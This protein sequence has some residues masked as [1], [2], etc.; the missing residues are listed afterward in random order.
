MQLALYSPLL[1]TVFSDFPLASTKYLQAGQVDDQAGDAALCGLSIGHFYRSST[2]ADT[3]IVRRTQ[4]HIHQF[5]DGF[6]LPL[7]CLQSETEYSIEHQEG[8]ESLVYV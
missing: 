4:L 5:E 6:E 1:G 3:A 8:A 7:N 2:L